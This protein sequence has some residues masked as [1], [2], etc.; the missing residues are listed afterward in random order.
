MVDVRKAAG[1]TLEYHKVISHF[2]NYM[3]PPLKAILLEFDEYLEIIA[4]RD[5]LLSMLS[6]RKELQ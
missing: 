4:R 1:D 6:N 2:S 5:S 3:D